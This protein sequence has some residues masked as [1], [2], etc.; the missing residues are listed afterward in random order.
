MMLGQGL[1]PPRAA[2]HCFAHDTQY[3]AHTT[4]A[5]FDIFRID[6]YVEP[7]FE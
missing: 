2:S 6:D 1:A 3:D 4:V 5:D 7:V